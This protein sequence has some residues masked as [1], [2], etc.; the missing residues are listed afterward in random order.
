MVVCLSIFFRVFW[1]RGAVDTGII[2]AQFT[3]VTLP[4]P[5]NFDIVLY[6]NVRLSSTSWT[7]DHLVPQEGVAGDLLAATDR[8]PLSDIEVDV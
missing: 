6:I 2:H 5:P 1:R 7:I 8:E 4:V 3:E